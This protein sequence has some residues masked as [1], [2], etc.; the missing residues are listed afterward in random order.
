[1]QRKRKI[2]S[3]QAKPALKDARGLFLARLIPSSSGSFI[4]K[5]AGVLIIPSIII[6]CLS[7]KMRQKRGFEAEVKTSQDSLAFIDI[8]ADGLVILPG[9]M[10]SRTIRFDDINY[11]LG[12]HEEK[13]KIF[14]DYMQFLN[15]FDS[16]VHCQLTFVNQTGSMSR[17]SIQ[18]PLMNDG[19]DSLRADL[20][21]MLNNQIEMGNNGIARSKYITFSVEAKT[22][23]EARQR[24]SRVEADAISSLKKM[25]VNAYSMTRVELA[26]VMHAILNPSGTP[27]TCTEE[28]MK[29]LGVKP[30]DFIAPKMLDFTDKRHCR[31][32]S[33][34]GE[35]YSST[36]NLMITASDISDRILA[37]FL[38]MEVE[39]VVTMHIKPVD[40]QKAIKMVKRKISDIGKM[41]ADEQSRLDRADG[42]AA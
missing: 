21:E 36:M 7:Q 13:N 30:K 27:F 17:S 12:H 10:Y 20:E 40:H 41:K 16:S 5:L 33:S 37:D 9:G 31:M 34:S 1:L 38:D 3:A 4:V 39:L 19:M 11:Q 6:E 42:A 26:K 35:K 25:A 28:S 15:S 23:K 8:R 32:V 18:I 24:L 2:A 22:E 14:A 29:R